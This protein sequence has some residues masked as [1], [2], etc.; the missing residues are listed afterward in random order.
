ME[1]SFAATTASETSE[2]EQT[3]AMRAEQA[4]IS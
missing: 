3:P 1:G 2:S 4:V